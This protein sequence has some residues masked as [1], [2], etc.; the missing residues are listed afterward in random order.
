M[1][2]FSRYG[3]IKQSKEALPARNCRPYQYSYGNRFLLSQ[4]SQYMPAAT[5]FCSGANKVEAGYPGIPRSINMG[6]T[7]PAMQRPVFE[8]GGRFVRL[9]ANACQLH[10]PNTIPIFCI[11]GCR[12]YRLRTFYGFVP[13]LLFFCSVHHYAL[14]D[15]EHCKRCQIHQ[16]HAGTGRGR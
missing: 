14:H 11:A 3:L 7:C 4:Q 8:G 2:V 9:S 5:I 12:D 1:S 6:I 10:R 13:I 16:H 15:A